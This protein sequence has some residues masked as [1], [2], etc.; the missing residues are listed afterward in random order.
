M[1][2]PDCYSVFVTVRAVFHSVTAESD[3]DEHFLGL[4]SSGSVFSSLIMGFWFLWYLTLVNVRL[5]VQQI[6]VAIPLSSVCVGWRDRPLLQAVTGNSRP[7]ISAIKT[8]ATHRG[9]GFIF[10][11]LVSVMEAG[12]WETGQSRTIVAISDLCCPAQHN[13]HTQLSVLNPCLM[14]TKVAAKPSRCGDT[15]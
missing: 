9:L 5:T 15:L 2:S 6:E 1:S 13:D 11:S 3:I 12:R 4:S 14:W 7:Y 10:S 8:C